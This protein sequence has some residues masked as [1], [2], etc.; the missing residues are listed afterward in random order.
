MTRKVTCFQ[1]NSGSGWDDD[2]SK[3]SHFWA[4]WMA[5]VGCFAI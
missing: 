4:V 3:K 2:G 5:G 1:Y